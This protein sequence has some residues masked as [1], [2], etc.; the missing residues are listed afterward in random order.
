MCKTTGEREE[1]VFQ[2]KQL[3]PVCKGSKCQHKDSNHADPE[4]DR[5]ANLG[6][7]PRAKAVRP[8]QVNEPS[9]GQVQVYMFEA[10]QRSKSYPA[11]EKGRLL[12]RPDD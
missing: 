6:A 12:A 8:Q 9:Q 1:P 11:A 5:V 3:V 7:I 2:L 10:Q 4:L